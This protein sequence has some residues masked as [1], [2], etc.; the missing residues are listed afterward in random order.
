LSIS[1]LLILVS[2][3]DV[4]SQA[5]FQ[6]EVNYNIHVKLNDKVHELNAFETVE[7][8]NH[9]PDTLRFLFFHLWPNGYSENDTPLAKELFISKGK[10]RLFND[11]E[12]KGYIDSLEF[13]VNNQSVR[14]SYL[15][16][17]PDICKIELSYSLKPGDTIHISTPF[18]VKIPKGVTSR[19]GHIGES[20]Q[21]SQWY[22]KPAVYD[23]LGWHQISY[24]DQGEYY[25][26]FGRFDVKITLP[27]NYI[28]GATGILQD[29]GEKIMLDKLAADTSWKASA[30]SEKVDFPSSSEQMKTLRYTGNHIHDFAWFADKRFH[31]VKGKVTLPGSGNEITTWAM[32]TNQ[33]SWLWKDAIH[34]VDK[35]IVSFSNWCGEY[36]YQSFTVVQSALNAGSGMEYPGLAVVGLTENAYVLEKVIAH[37]IAHTWFYST[38]GSDERR[39]PF[40][41]EGITS[42]YEARYMEL[43]YPGKK[44]WEGFIKN[45]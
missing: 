28:V 34:Y 35:A 8:I 38:L 4:F 3:F 14:W 26:E 16:S 37:E 33:Q 22:P 29:E 6:Q 40:M 7:Y 12:L 39:Y 5:Y 19:L 1:I 2:S 27:S 9:S 30:G 45:I 11:P 23:R 44:I 20:Y 13:R 31:V 18:H 36:P 42:A 15:P 32:F 24:L 25:S 17:Q 43:L 41:D 10:E 21:I